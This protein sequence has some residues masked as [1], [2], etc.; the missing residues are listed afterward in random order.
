MEW[1]LGVVIMIGGPLLGFIIA[2]LI[3]HSREVKY[4]IKEQATQKGRDTR[5]RVKHQRNARLA[6]QARQEL[7]KARRRSHRAELELWEIEFK[8]IA[9]SKSERVALANSTLDNADRFI[10]E[11]VRRE[12]KVELDAAKRA[13]KEI[14]QRNWDREAPHWQLPRECPNRKDM[15]IIDGVRRYCCAC[16]CDGGERCP[17]PIE[18]HVIGDLKPVNFCGGHQRATTIY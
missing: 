14:Q 10:E 9:P 8:Q 5:R 1:M 17:N 12:V 13:D 2:Q 15:G 16:P 11:E 18:V 6:I 7:S 3:I 4:W